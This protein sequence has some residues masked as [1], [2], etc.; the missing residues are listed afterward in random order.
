MTLLFLDI[1]LTFLDITMT[2]HDNY[3]QKKAYTNIP[4]KKS[5]S[6]IRDGFL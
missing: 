4:R 6:F 2:F 1:V 5:V 3:G